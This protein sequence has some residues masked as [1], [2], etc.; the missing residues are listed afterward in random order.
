MADHFHH[1]FTD[2][3]DCMLTAIAKLE[4][5]LRDSLARERTVSHGIPV[6][7]PV[8]TEP[9]GCMAMPGTNAFDTDSSSSTTI[10]EI[11]MD[12]SS[13]FGPVLQEFAKRLE[14]IE[15][16][17]DQFP[18]PEQVPTESESM[19]DLLTIKS[20]PASRNVLVSSVRN[21]P[22]L[23]AAIAAANPPPI[24]LH[25]AFIQNE[26][27]MTGQLSATTSEE[28]EEE[29]AGTVEEEEDDS[30]GFPLKQVVIQGKPYFMDSDNTVYTETDEGYEEIGTYDPTLD[31]VILHGEEEQEEEQEQEQDDV[32]VV[33]A[34]EE[35]EESTAL[36]VEEIVYKGQ[37]YYKDESNSVYTQDM[38]LIGEWTGTRIKRIA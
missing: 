6:A 24:T 17:F 36:E 22:A 9:W 1:A 25:T 19:N 34:T 28:D 30:E 35:D 32:L 4:F 29:D 38:I 31:K 15:K 8:C 18:T 10:S 33:D 23:S 12:T 16:K 20:E 37:K 27:T 7:S 2:F 14:A 11:P 5:Q 13:L 21:T 3:R 26:S